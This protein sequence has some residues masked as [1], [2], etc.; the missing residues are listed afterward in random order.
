M[1]SALT[2]DYLGEFGSAVKAKAIANE[3][4]SVETAATGAGSALKAAA[5]KAKDP[6][7]NLRKVT[8]QTSESIKAAEAAGATLASSLGGVLKGLIDGTTDWKEASMSA[9]KAIL[10]YSNQMNV[11]GGG[12]GL[13]GGGFFQSLLGGLIGIP[14]FANGTNYAPG[15]VAL[16]GERG[17]ELVNLPRGSQ[18]VPNH[19]MKAANGM[20]GAT[21][22]DVRVGIDDQ[23]ALRAY[24]A[25]ETAASEARVTRS[26]PKI[27]DGRMAQS[28]LRGVRA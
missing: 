6:W 18:V 21:T 22:V 14:G 13:F 8:D 24:V 12:K 16:V 2:R 1:A 5:D 25:K 26:V 11:A 9:F 27:V 10:Q 23:G 15:G 17:P 19:R 3:L 4:A 7:E 20:G 28:Q